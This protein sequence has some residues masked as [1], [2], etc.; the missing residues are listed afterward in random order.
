MDDIL[1]AVMG[2]LGG[3]GI[4]QIARS[5]G[6]DKTTTSSAIG[7][8]VPLLVS[9]LAKNASNPAGAQ[10]LHGALARDHDGG[11][12]DD[13]MGFL[14]NPQSMNGVG[15]LKHVLGG[16]MGAVQQG[17]SKGSGLD[18]AAVG[19]LL[20][21]LAPIV[22]GFLGRQQKTQGLD[23]GALAGM[24][25]GH[26]QQASGLLGSLNSLLDSDGDGSAIDDIGRMAKGLFGGN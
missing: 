4:G 25:G 16:K 5:I 3:D 6:A 13:L 7:T 18:S 8:A 2:Q 17:I 1:K 26:G 21:I 10:A 19:K 22:M 15:I 9:A 24:L 12:L 14:G 23:A 20:M 11:I